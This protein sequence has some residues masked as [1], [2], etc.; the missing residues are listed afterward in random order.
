MSAAIPGTPD[1]KAPIRLLSS[2]PAPRTVAVFNWYVDRGEPENWL[3]GLK[4]AVQADRLSDHR[5]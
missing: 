2:T 3:K 4:N 5:L 1:Q